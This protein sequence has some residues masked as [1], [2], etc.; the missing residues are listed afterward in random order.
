[1]SKISGD[2]GSSLNITI[3]VKIIALAN[4]TVTKTSVPVV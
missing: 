1:M 2:I 4:I 3:T